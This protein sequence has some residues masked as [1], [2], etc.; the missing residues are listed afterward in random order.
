[1]EPLGVE[2]SR[3]ERAAVAGAALIV[4]AQVVG[5]LVVCFERSLEVSERAAVI[6]IGWGLVVVALLPGLPLL[7]RNRTSTLGRGYLAGLS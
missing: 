2:R 1:V 3:P 4:V 6:S 7:E 5:T